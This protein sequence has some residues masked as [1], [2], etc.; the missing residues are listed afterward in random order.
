LW[1]KNIRGQV[2]KQKIWE[3]IALTVV[4]RVHLNNW[5]KGGVGEKKK[6]KKNRAITRKKGTVQQ[7]K[8]GPQL[9]EAHAR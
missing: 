4:C 5:Q 7:A 9:R 6:Q 3:K 1:K 2:R 8:N